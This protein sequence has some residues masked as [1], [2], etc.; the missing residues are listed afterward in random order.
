MTDILFDL[1]S[2][3]RQSIMGKSIGETQR[4]AKKP[5]PEKIVPPKQ[6]TYP[7]QPPQKIF[8]EGSPIQ[9]TVGNLP[10][11]KNE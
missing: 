4:E 3:I 5:E 10:M 9:R 6:P 2:K 1:E 8:V 11:I 7:L